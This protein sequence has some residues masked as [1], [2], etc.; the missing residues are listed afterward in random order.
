MSAKRATTVVSTK[1][2]VILPKDIRDAMQWRP[3]ARLTVERTPEGVLLKE[4][5]P[6]PTL[7]VEDVAGMFKWDGPPASLEDMDAAI[8][9]EVIRRHERG[10]Y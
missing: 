6:R 9:A 2:Q 5:I 8:A 4:D 3:G 1:G 7:A 10:R